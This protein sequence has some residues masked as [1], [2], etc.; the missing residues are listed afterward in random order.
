[1]SNKS[2]LPAKT[3]KTAVKGRAGISSIVPFG[4][5]K[6]KPNHF[7]EMAGVVWE[8]RD[9]LPYAWSILKHGVCDG[10]SLGPRGLEDDV[11]EGTHLCMSRLKLL[12]NNTVGAFAEADVAD[13]ERLRRM[14]NRELRE[15]GRIPYPFIYRPGMRGF[16]RISWDEACQI[17]GQILAETPPSRQAYF[18]TSKGLTNE[19]YY[20]FTKTARLMGTNNVDFC[21]RLCHAATVS[22]LSQTI[23]VGAPTISLDDLIGTDLI[24]LWGTNLA[25][26]QPVSVKYLHHAKKSGT[27]IV[28]INTLQEKGLDNYWIPSIPKSALFGT[29][30]AD[31][32]IQVNIG[33]DLALMN[34][35]IKLLISWG[36][37]NHDFI[38]AH[39]SGWADLTAHLDTL[40]LETLVRQSGV[41]LS[42]IEWLA[43]LIARSQTMVT[44]YSMGLTQ[45]KFGTQNVMG[46]VNLHLSKGAIGKS[47]SGILPIRGHSGVQ[48]GGE[49]GVTPNKL[50]G[51]FK[52][53]SENV[54]RFTELWGH[55]VPT[56]PGMATGAMLEAAFEGKID[57]LYNLGGNLVAT[58]PQP[59]WVVEGFQR[60]RLRIHQDINLNTSAL[61]EPKEA[62]LLLPAQTRYE[63]KGGGTSTSTERRIRFSPEIPGH[64][65]VGE[66]KPEYEI[67]A[68]IAAAAKPNLKDA[69]CFESSQA[70]RDEMARVMPVY[71]RINELSKE[72]DHWQWGGAQLCANG[73]FAN[74]P[75]C[76]ASFSILDAPETEVPEGWFKMTTRRGKQ[77]NS[78]VFSSKDTLQ[79]GARRNDVLLSSQDAER[80]GLSEGTPINLKN[81]LGIFKG[82]ARIQNIAPG[83]I[84]TYWP[85]S[86]MLIERCFDPISQ[87]PDYHCLVQISKAVQ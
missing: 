35:L 21:A 87:E 68:L 79:G 43:T 45:H 28:S 18:A 7:I 19:T 85:E 5:G 3:D 2:I 62:I 65:Q 70:I 38:E 44:V 86:N 73:D 1:M 26:N 52:V 81:D 32:F 24:L 27:R 20:S 33:G 80:L 51:G 42:K 74:M 71:H 48:G 4:L 31:D 41:P 78:M 15:L 22:G 55:P 66:C 77:F 58:M 46:V 57:V 6:T 82:I 12:R 8:N 30:L 60:V 64:P 50:P 40:E 39:T 25:N 75:D 47:K 63:Q 17:G 83:Y 49:C 69:L 59:E 23:G 29:K 72:G 9:Q 56:E 61:V 10:C 11:I 37:V 34:A 36:T 16:K 14:T 84:Q 76:R 53:N 67:P 13:I 54:A